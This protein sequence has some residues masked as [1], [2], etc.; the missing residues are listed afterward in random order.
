MGFKELVA[1]D[2]HD[3]FLNTAEYGETRNI[4]YDGELYAGIPIVLSGAREQDRQEGRAE[5]DTPGLYMVTA[6][7]H[8]ALSDL[9]GNQPEQGMRIK[10]SRTEDAES[11]YD[12]YY[13]VDSNCEIGM[14]DLKLGVTDE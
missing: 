9:G 11:W 4:L 3:V 2:I 8:C 10:I 14:V 7:L 5:N 13:I 6:V 12:E 1:K